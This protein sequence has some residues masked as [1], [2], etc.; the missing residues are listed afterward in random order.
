[1]FEVRNTP[2]MPLS[3]YVTFV[4]ARICD[5]LI[6]TCFLRSCCQL[7]PLHFL[8]AVT[9]VKKKKKAR[10]HVCPVLFHF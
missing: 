1:M 8:V 9:D 2:E 10:V 7:T 5:E 6:P 4:C 3:T